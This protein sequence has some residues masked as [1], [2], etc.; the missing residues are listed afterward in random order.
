MTTTENA[1][2]TETTTT[3]IKITPERAAWLESLGLGV[4]CNNGREFVAASYLV[5]LG[6]TVTRDGW[7]EVKPGSGKIATRFVVSYQNGEWAF[8]R[9]ESG[10]G[11]RMVQGS[12]EEAFRAARDQIR[13]YRMGWAGYTTIKGP[14]AA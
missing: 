7:T 5:R 12:R 13:A 1:N 8:T 6:E 10:R 14:R 4:E 3:T 11:V 2:M 9:Y